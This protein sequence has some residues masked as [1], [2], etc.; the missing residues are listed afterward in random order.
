MNERKIFPGLQEERAK[1]GYEDPFIAAMGGKHDQ[2][3][4]RSEAAFEDRDA[5]VVVDEAEVVTKMAADA[6]NAGPVI[7][8][9]QRPTEIGK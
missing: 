5:R 1:V 4:A 9:G 2:A 8:D 3:T 6:Q 7:I